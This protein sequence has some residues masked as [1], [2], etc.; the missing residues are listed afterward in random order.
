L[1][2]RK[3]Y[4]NGQVVF[5]HP[6]RAGEKAPRAQKKSPC[7]RGF[8]RNQR[9]RTVPITVVGAIGGTPAARERDRRLMF[10]MFPG[11][12]GDRPVIEAISSPSGEFPLRAR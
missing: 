1:A 8:L 11:T 3:G 4:P 6:G 10:G 9:G 5:G 12:S 2:V 7:N